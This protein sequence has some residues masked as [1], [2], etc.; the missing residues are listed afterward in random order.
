[1]TIRTGAQEQMFRRCPSTGRELRYILSNI[2][3]VRRSAM[4]YRGGSRG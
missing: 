3:S 4:A 2:P 1:M